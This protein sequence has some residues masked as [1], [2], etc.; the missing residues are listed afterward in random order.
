MIAI[1]ISSI[2]RSPALSKEFLKGDDAK[3]V[4]FLFW[5]A[6]QLWPRFTQA[7][8]FND[9]AIALFVLD[10]FFVK[11]V[12]ARRSLDLLRSKARAAHRL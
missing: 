8:L 10:V 5:A 3:A 4:A 6:N 1:L 9:I 11:S 12:A 7:P 2:R